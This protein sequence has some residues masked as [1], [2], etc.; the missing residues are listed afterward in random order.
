MS[1]ASWW[2]AVPASS[3]AA[4]GDLELDLADVGPQSGEAV[5][6]RMAAAVV[7]GRADPQQRGAGDDV[8]Q[9]G[10]LGRGH[11]DVDDDPGVR[12][13]GGVLAAQVLVQRALR[14]VR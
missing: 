10:L 8:E 3:P 6:Q 11:A 1:T 5:D 13:V 4:D 2:R 14:E 9:L 12:E 7:H